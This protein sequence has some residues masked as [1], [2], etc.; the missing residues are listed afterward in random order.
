[1]C[2]HHFMKKTDDLDTGFPLQRILCMNRV[3]A[4][5]TV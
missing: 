2:F 4:Y 5:A 3:S 1:M